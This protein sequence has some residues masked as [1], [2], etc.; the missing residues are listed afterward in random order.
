MCGVCDFQISML[1]CIFFHAVVVVVVML[2]L[3][4]HGK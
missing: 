3:F 1:V 4:I 2:L